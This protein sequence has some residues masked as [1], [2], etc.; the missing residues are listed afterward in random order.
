[1]SYSVVLENPFGRVASYAARILQGEKAGDL[2]IQ[3][4]SKFR[5]VINRKTATALGLKIPQ[6]LVLQ[7]DQIIE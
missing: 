5:L 2:P 1:M 4:P 3:E 6:V 7:A